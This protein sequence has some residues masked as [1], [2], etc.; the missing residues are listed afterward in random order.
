MAQTGT[1]NNI[2]KMPNTSPPIHAPKIGTSAL[3]AT[4]AETAP[5]YGI[6]RISIP[7]KHRTPMITASVSCPLTK[8]VKVW[9][10][11]EAMS[12][13]HCAFFAEGLSQ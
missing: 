4:N 8:F 2:P 5:A 12:R 6:P 11:R 13:N 1:L 3:M 7:I 10:V 9:L